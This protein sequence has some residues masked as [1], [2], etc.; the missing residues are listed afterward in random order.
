[1]ICLAKRVKPDP[2]F[3]VSVA[4]LCKS[5]T[6]SCDVPLIELK[7]I[8]IFFKMRIGMKEIIA[9]FILV[10]GM[11]SPSLAT[12][13]GDVKAGEAVFNHACKF[14]HGVGR[15]GAPRIG[16]KAAWAGRIAQGE[17]KLTD[18]AFLGYRN[19]PARGNCDICSDQDIINAVAYIVHQSK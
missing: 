19:M 10:V 2:V 1:M 14:C 6:I 7:Q 18:H 11:L 3:P 9:T 5:A 13:G 8:A 4:H 16:D 12:A 15:M 17:S